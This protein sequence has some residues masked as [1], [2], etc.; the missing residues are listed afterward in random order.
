MSAVEAVYHYVRS[1]QRGTWH[2]V[3]VIGNVT[4]SSERCNLDDAS[5]RSTQT[6][7]PPADERRCRWCYAPSDVG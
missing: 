7:E 2:R 3:V 6:Y 4:R 5:I 1:Q